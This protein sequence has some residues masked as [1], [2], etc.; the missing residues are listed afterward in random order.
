MFALINHRLIVT[1]ESGGNEPLLRQ[2]V[3][4]AKGKIVAITDEA[5]VRSEWPQCNTVVDLGGRFLS[6][7]LIDLQVRLRCDSNIREVRIY[8][9]N[10][11]THRCMVP[12]VIYLVVIPLLRP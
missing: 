5:A 4:V 2:A 10:S 9:L 6:P 8:S 3:V 12:G 1:S 7:G 11:V